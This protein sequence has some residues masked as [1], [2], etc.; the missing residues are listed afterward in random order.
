MQIRPGTLV[1]FHVLADL[2]DPLAGSPR[3]LSLR[4]TALIG[5]AP[6]LKAPLRGSFA[7]GQ[8]LLVLQKIDWDERQGEVIDLAHFDFSGESAKEADSI[9]SQARFQIKHP[10]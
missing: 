3:E 9:R 4:L 1:S 5:R 10:A 8:R 6:F 2:A 7:L